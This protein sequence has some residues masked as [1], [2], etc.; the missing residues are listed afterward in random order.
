MNIFP[1][2]LLGEAFGA[3][4]LLLVFV[5]ALILFGPKNLPKI[6]RNL[7]RALEEFRRATR[8]VTDEIMRSDQEP[9]PPQIPPT[10]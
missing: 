3:P 4:E 9:P 7:G 8:D 2:A 6:A 10:S 1:V 5:V